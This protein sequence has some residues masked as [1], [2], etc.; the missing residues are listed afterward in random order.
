MK[1]KYTSKLLA[2]GMITNS[3]LIN[4]S[5]TKS[6]RGF[7]TVSG[8]SGQVTKVKIGGSQ[9]KWVKWVVCAILVLFVTFFAVFPLVTFILESLEENS[10]DITSITLRYWITTEELDVRLSA[11]GQSSQGILHNFTR[12]Q[13]YYIFCIP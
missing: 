10:G 2:L 4:N 11:Q 6:R 1:F 7:T 3:L 13:N 5:F 12:L 9:T 8:K